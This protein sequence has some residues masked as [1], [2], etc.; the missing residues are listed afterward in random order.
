MAHRLRYA[1]SDGPLATKLV[2]IVGAGET[3]VGGRREG[4]TDRPC[5]ATLRSAAV[6]PDALDAQC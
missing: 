2:G 6:L 4:R 3:D 5:A 1:M